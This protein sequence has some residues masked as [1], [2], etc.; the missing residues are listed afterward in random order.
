MNSVLE[1]I[2][3]VAAYGRPTYGNVVLLSWHAISN[4]V[5]L[6]N[7]ALTAAVNE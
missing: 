3:K 1:I 7:I 5:W 4:Q 6:W 2:R